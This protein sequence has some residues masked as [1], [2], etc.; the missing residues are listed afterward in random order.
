MISGSPPTAR[1]ALT[2]LFTPPTNT[3]SARS[4]ISR[5]RR[6]SGLMD[7][8]GVLIRVERPRLASAV[9]QPLCRIL[10]V[11]GQNNI[12]PCALNSC[13]NFQHGA[14]LLKPTLVRRCLD[15]R[16]FAAD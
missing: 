8:V 11:V 4:K 2:G 13:Q 10:C 3:V 5:E 12:C 15:H 7:F 6:L 14:L 9:P 1:N 16:I